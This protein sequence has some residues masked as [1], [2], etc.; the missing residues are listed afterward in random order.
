MFKL[1]GSKWL[2][3]RKSPWNYGT[4]FYISSFL[5]ST[6]F[7]NNM[8]T[9]SKRGAK[10]KS[11]LSKADGLKIGSLLS[12]PKRLLGAT[13]PKDASSK[14]TKSVATQHSKKLQK[15]GK[16][17]NLES[18]SVRVFNDASSSRPSAIP[19]SKPGP[20]DAEF[21]SMFEKPALRWSRPLPLPS[22]ET[23]PNPGRKNSAKPQPVSQQLH[24]KRGASTVHQNSPTVFPSEPLEL[25]DIGEKWPVE[26]GRNRPVEEW[27]SELFRVQEAFAS[28]ELSPPPPP[29]KLSSICN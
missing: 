1:V 29:G 27:P 22:P 17:V 12:Q 6:S 11:S 15:R 8:L 20:F 28:P 19:G 10:V 9:Y 24:Y 26:F 5:P 2:E 25:P 13:D 16:K 14:A 18:E 23:V 7:P 21:E 3:E 4:L